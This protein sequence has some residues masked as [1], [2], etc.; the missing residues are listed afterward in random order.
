MDV[1]NVSQHTGLYYTAAGPQQRCYMDAIAHEHCSPDQ[2]PLYVSGM[3]RLSVETAVS[4]LDGAQSDDVNFLIDACDEFVFGSDLKRIFDGSLPVRVVS[5]VGCIA[6]FLPGTLGGRVCDLVDEWLYGSNPFSS[7]FE[8][9]LRTIRARALQDSESGIAQVISS[10]FEKEVRE[11]LAENANATRIPI[12]QRL[13]DDDM[14]LLRDHFPRYELRFTQNVDG[15]HNM[16][17]AH[18]A[19]EVRELVDSFPRDCPLID[20]GGNWFGHFRYGR[21]HVHSCCPLLDLRD[22]ERQTTRMVMAEHLMSTLRSKFVSI[23]DTDEGALNRSAKD[24]FKEFLKRW[25]VHPCDLTRAYK[26]LQS[27]T[28]DLYCHNAFGEERERKS[29]SSLLKASSGSRCEDSVVNPHCTFKAKYAIMVHSGYDLDIDALIRGMH[30][31]GIEKLKGTM[32]ADPAMLVNTSGYLPALKCYWEKKAGNIWFSFKDDSTMGYRHL[33]S[34]YSRYLTCTVIKS[35]LSDDCYVMERDK[36]R[37]GTLSYT[38]TR[39]TGALRPGCHEF[40][41]NAWFTEMF[42]K[43]LMRVP[44]IKVKDL[45]GLPGSI[46]CSWRHIVTSRRLVDRVIEVCLRGLKTS[47]GDAFNV[48]AASAVQHLD[49]LKIIQNHLLSHSQTLVLNG[50]TI[51]REEAIPFKDFSP[52]SL[53]IYFEIM[54]TRY[55][56]GLA[57]AWF[58]SSFSE[59]FHGTSFRAFLKETLWRILGFP[60]RCLDFV[61]K[62]L[63]SRGMDDLTFI[64]EAVEKKTVLQKVYLPD[65]KKS[66]LM[67]LKDFD[68]SLFFE[69]IEQIVTFEHVESLAAA[70]G[71]LNSATDE[72]TPS[73]SM[74]VPTSQVQPVVIEAF[75]YYEAEI[76]RIREKCDRVLNVYR[77]LGNCGGYRNDV[78][79]VGLYSKTAGWVLK[80]DEYSHE[81]GWNGSAF[82]TIEWQG[83]IPE[84]PGDTVV[85][86]ETTKVMTNV[87]LVKKYAKLPTVVLPSVSIIDGVTGC[88]KTTEIVRTASPDTLILSVC[89]A[90]VLEIRKKLPGNDVRIRTLDSYLLNP[91]VKLPHLFLDEFSLAHPG[92]IFLAVFLSGATQ[93]KL[94]G[95]TEQIPFC[96]RV[97]DLALKFPDL[98]SSHME[99]PR[100]V[101]TVTYRCPHDITYLLSKM[102]TRKT[103]ETRSSVETSVKIREVKSENEIPLPNSFDG[104]VIYIAMTKHDVSLL[105]LRWAKEGITNDV[106]TVHAAQGL[107]VKH[108]VYFRLMRTDND[109]YT[110]KKLPY[111]LVAISRHTTSLTYCTTKGEDDKDYSLKMLKSTFKVSRGFKNPS[112]GT[113][114]AANPDGVAH[115][116][117]VSFK[118]ST[119]SVESHHQVVQPLFEQM[120]ENLP[121]AGAEA[122]IASTINYPVSSEAVYSKEVPVYGHIPEAKGKASANPASIIMAIEELTPGNTTVP[123]ED[124]DDIVEVSPISLQLG[125]LRWDLSKMSPRLFSNNPFAVPYL[126]T[127]AMPR[128]NVSAKQVGAAIEK[129][130]ANCLNSTGFFSME[131]VANKAVSRFFSLFI[132]EEKFSRLPRGVLGSSAEH[133]Q[134]YQNKTGNT[135]EACALSATNISKYH[136]MIKRDVKP[137]LTTA[138]QS[139]YTK[140]AT[141]TYHKP[142][143]T[144]IATSIFGQFKTRLLQCRAA[145]VNFP[146]DHDSDLSGYLTTYHL[147]SEQ[148]TFTEI[149]FSKF[150][151][152]QGELHQLIQDKI[153]IKFG[154]DPEFVALWSTA[155]RSSSIFDNNVGIGFKTDFQRRTGDAFTFLG[156]SLVTAAMLAYVIDDFDAIRYILVGGD[157]SLICSYGPLTVPLEPLETIF[158]M[159]CKLIQPA[160][161]Y[162]ASRYLV[163][164]NDEILCVPDPYKLLVKMGRRDVPDSAFALEEVRKG[165]ADS[166]KYLADDEVKMKLS[167]LVQV[168]YGKASPNLYDALCTIHW[169]LATA[170]NFRSLFNIENKSNEIRRKFRGVKIR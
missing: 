157:D 80:P 40:F 165:L 142:D 35:G 96:N 162:F 141:I 88:G 113:I 5:A 33:W 95:D 84:F 164:R 55:K 41:H 127:G 117:S 12:P 104:E 24:R 64:T 61:V 79:C 108:V 86:S 65:G 136:H 9:T 98:E 119:S 34:V 6:H 155:H 132:D 90:N 37:H 94:F 72:P 170:S 139:D 63:F 146:L 102:Y 45:K 100:D 27:G 62:A 81:M 15:P 1:M 130:N 3:T 70:E 17:A 38:I 163:R 32:I 128:R 106:R 114:L 75:R 161:P 124:L 92:F 143:I 167:I 76:S 154:V 134:L 21:Q 137:V 73:N 31:H 54:V 159:S 99:F 8:E 46:E 26:R 4:P 89:K 66:G 58:E 135:P 111:H 22:N 56:E 16:A 145:K 7:E 109:L 60:K 125:R 116:A 14:R 25:I 29:I 77:T 93:V 2:L 82:V 83:R 103:I 43:Y 152:S 105:K 51:I 131:D 144:Q 23:L 91:T 147:G 118:G 169:A 44:H 129:R 71:E 140:A 87:K 39:C 115:R 158:N 20:I 10:H 13:G 11:S 53:T 49:N 133:I 153:L 148:D 123:T 74:Q 97:A 168:R 67:S 151:K 107:S 36:Y 156:N 18:R 110:K 101:R 120:E 85:V 42:D 150:D 112:L 19:L 68:D 122:I 57:V 28:S 166:A 52:M 69:T 160:C 59:D 50:A 48:A 138:L 149:D 47:A 30:Y 121:V 78:E 126:A